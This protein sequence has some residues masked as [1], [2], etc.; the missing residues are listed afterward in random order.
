[1]KQFAMII[2][3]SLFALFSCTAGPKTQEKETQAEGNKTVSLIDKEQFLTEVWNYKKSPDKW[4]FLGNK[5]VIIDFYADWCGP[6]KIASPILEEVASEYS[7]QIIVYK[8]NTDAERELASVFN[9]QSIP[10][11]L[12]IPVDGKPVMTAG[13]G[14]SKDQTKQMFID[15]IKTYLLK[16]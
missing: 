4:Q 14:R 1:M 5:P 8:I 9:I 3:M 11:F 16:K 10:T 6:C 7:E 12:Y 2:S 13:I 15:N